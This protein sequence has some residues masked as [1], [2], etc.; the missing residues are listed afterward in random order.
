MTV[1]EKKQQ[2]ITQREYALDS[3]EL[4]ASFGFILIA[5]QQH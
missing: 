3:A 5:M 2:D 4:S 1:L